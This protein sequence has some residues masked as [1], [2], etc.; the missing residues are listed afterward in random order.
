MS[1]P[2][3]EPIELDVATAPVPD[4]PTVTPSGERLAPVID[5]VQTR[6]VVVQSDERGS[7]SEIFNP[8]WGFTSEPLV[9]VYETTVHPGQKKAWIV[10]LQQDDRLF[11]NQGAAKVV[12]YDAR[13]GSPTKGMISE[14]FVGAAN[15]MLL[16]IPAGV[17]H[18]VVNVGPET[19]R[20][21]NLPTQPYHHD[22]P[23][24]LR[25]PTD[26]EAIPYRI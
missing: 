22:R 10:H 6:A 24:K 15:R 8:A 3:S 16:R 7:V 20:F 23:D 26:S 14:L 2:S 17:F 12:L 18:G 25:L 1:P 5:G 13:V 19:L 21:I 11:F 9:Y 4:V